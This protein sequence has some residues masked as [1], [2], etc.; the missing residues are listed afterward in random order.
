MV[1]FAAVLTEQK[2]ND[3]AQA[4]NVNGMRPRVVAIPQGATTVYRVV[5]GPYGTRE[6]AEKTGRDSGRPYWV[7]EENQ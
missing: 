2:A 6:E 4:I 3:A 5:L 1:S 7:Y